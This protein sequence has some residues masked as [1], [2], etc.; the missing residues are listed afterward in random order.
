VPYVVISVIATAEDTETT[1]DSDYTAYCRGRSEERTPIH[2]V[3]RTCPGTLKLCLSVNGLTDSNITHTEN[4]VRSSPN[5]SRGIRL[6]HPGD[7]FLTVFIFY[8]LNEICSLV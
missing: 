1:R 7:I 2:Y 3:D 5:G 8:P 6:A 4:P